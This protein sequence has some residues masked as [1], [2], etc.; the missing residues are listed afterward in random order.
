MS[1]ECLGILF[2]F[3]CL[4]YIVLIFA[5]R[6]PDKTNWQG[7]EEQGGEERITIE[8]PMPRYP[9]TMFASIFDAAATEIRS[10]FL[11]SYTL[12]TAN[13]RARSL[14]Y[15]VS[16]VYTNS[17]RT[18]T[19]WHIHFRTAGRPWHTTGK[20]GRYASATLSQI[21][22]EKHVYCTTLVVSSAHKRRI[23]RDT[24]TSSRRSQAGALALTGTAW[25]AHAPSMSSPQHHPPWYQEGTD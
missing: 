8:R 4:V 13:A 14:V 19:V 25:P 22:T 6:R 7:E 17:V 11:S 9:Q 12:Q 1:N 18:F 3:A 20:V 21:V 10:L 5:A 16:L 2:F 23:P 15:Q 24:R